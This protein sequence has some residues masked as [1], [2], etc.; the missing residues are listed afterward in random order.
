MF[1]F[2]GQKLEGEILNSFRRL[3]FFRDAHKNSERGGGGFILF[4]HDPTT[5]K[6]QL[7]GKNTFEGNP[8]ATIEANQ[9]STIRMY[10]FRNN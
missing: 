2:S 4:Y 8:S 10:A 3:L 1:H 9:V 5:A 6:L 7:S